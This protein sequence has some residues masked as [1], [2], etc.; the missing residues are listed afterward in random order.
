MKC[1]FMNRSRRDLENKKNRMKKYQFSASYETFQFR[2]ETQN[3][4]LKRNGVFWCLHLRPQASPL[5]F[6]HFGSKRGSKCTSLFSLSEC[7]I[8]IGWWVLFRSQ[9][10]FRSNPM[11]ISI[12]FW[13]VRFL[14]AVDWRVEALN[15]I[16]FLYFFRRSLCFDEKK[17]T[18]EKIE[19]R[20]NGCWDNWT[21]M[22][23]L[24]VF[25]KIFNCLPKYLSGNWRK[26]IFSFGNVFY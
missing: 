19:N 14:A 1:T 4:G 16:R 5:T 24:A 2:K 8:L 23:F 10:A 13:N 18:A 20:S 15:L 26:L 17:V 3:L 11:F 12:R 6:I 22:Q 9:C 21:N 7:C 25:S